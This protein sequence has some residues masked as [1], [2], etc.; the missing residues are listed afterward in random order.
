MTVTGGEIDDIG[1][2]ERDSI[3]LH[4][5]LE[6]VV[7]AQKLSTKLEVWEYPDPLEKPMAYTKLFDEPSDDDDFLQDDDDL[8]EWIKKQQSDPSTREVW[9]DIPHI[10]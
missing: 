5:D 8:S 2:R 4:R 3:L 1:W 6:N 9:L 10:E 7:E